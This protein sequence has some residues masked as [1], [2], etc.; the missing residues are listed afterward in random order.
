MPVAGIH[1]LKSDRWQL[2]QPAD[3]W[4]DEVA[5]VFVVYLVPPRLQLCS[6]VFLSFRMVRIV[7]LNRRV[8]IEAERH[9]IVDMRTLFVE[10]GD[11][12][13]NSYEL[14]TKTAMTLTPQEHP[15]F[16][17]FLE[18]VLPSGHRYPPDAE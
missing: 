14:P 6:R 1:D 7:V 15:Q 18:I 8:A 4:R 2:R 13:A 9:G 10:M 17:G 5:C 16:V 11:F 12:D 3:H